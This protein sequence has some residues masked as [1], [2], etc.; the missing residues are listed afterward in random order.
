MWIWSNLWVSAPWRSFQNTLKNA[1]I[2]FHG[3]AS[4][5]MGPAA[6]VTVHLGTLKKNFLWH[7]NDLSTKPLEGHRN[8]RFHRNPSFFHRHRN[9]S[10]Y[11]RGGGVGARYT[12]ILFSLHIKTKPE[13]VQLILSKHS[14]CGRI[15][16]LTSS[17]KTP[18][19]TR[20]VTF[21]LAAFDVR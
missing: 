7:H 15:F 5:R 19:I 6:I 18:K 9:T 17:K 21:W 12:L 11:I 10:N 16:P 4:W 20:V 1:A 2:L 14:L 8:W 13:E 3:R